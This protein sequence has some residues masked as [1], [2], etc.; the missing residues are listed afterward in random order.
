MM[1]GSRKMKKVRA[2]KCLRVSSEA[3]EI[4][5]KSCNATVIWFRL[6]KLGQ[7]GALFGLSN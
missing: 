7:V 6:G 2:E 4:A 5:Q 3:V 1:G